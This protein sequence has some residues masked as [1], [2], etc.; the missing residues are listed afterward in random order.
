LLFKRDLGE[1][2]VNGSTKR[3][4]AR[5][6]DELFEPQTCS[7]VTIGEAMVDR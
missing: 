7:Q 3:I 2:F 1:L 4:S 6:L 5:V